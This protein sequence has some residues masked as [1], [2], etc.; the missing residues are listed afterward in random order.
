MLTRMEA[1]S[2]RRLASALI[3]SS[4]ALAAG[5]C[6]RTVLGLTATETF[7][8]KYMTNWGVC[9]LNQNGSSVTGTCVRGTVMSCAAAGKALACDWTEGKGA[10]KAILAKQTDGRLTGTWGS[11]TS[12]VNGGAWTF[13]PQP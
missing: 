13:T 1:V 2:L 3:L 7:G 6:C 12:T 8:G 4:L 9:N 10:G 5:G 11:G